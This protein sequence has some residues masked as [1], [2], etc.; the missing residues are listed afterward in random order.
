MRRRNILASTSI[1]SQLLFAF[2]L[3][4]L[5]PAIVISV[6]SA[7]TSY[8]IGRQ[9][10]LDQ[11]DSVVTLKSAEMDMWTNELGV[12]LDMLLSKRDMTESVLPLLQGRRSAADGRQ[13]HDDI[14][15]IL[16]GMETATHLFEYI[17]LMDA[18]GRVIVS[19]N[20]ALDGRDLGATVY[21]Q[22]GLQKN[23]I[24]P[25]FRED[26]RR[27]SS[28]DQRSVSS[29]LIIVAA[30]PIVAP[31]LGAVGVL[32]GFSDIAVLD[33]IMKEPMG[34]GDNCESYLIGSDYAPLTQLRFL[35]YPSLTEVKSSGVRLAVENKL[36]GHSAYLDYRGTPVIGSHAW[37]PV[38][39]VALIVELDQAEA[40]GPVTTMSIANLVV[41]LISVL[42]AILAASIITR[43][44]SVPLHAL[45]VTATQI[46]SGDLG[47]DA[48]V[49]RRDEIGNLA[50]AFNN[51]TGQLRNMIDELRAE[52]AERGRVEAEL[53]ASEERN[54]S[55]L[56]GAMDGFWRVDLRGQLLE[57]NQA[58]CHMSGY[59]ERELLAMDITDL[60]AV[61][62]QPETA[63]HI[64]KVMALGEDRFETRH[65]RKDGSAF[66][67][68]ISVQYKHDEGDSLLAFLRDITGRRQS[69]GQIRKSLAEKET[70]LKE[71][72]HRTKNNMGII[73]ALLN[74][75][76]AD[77]DDERVRTAF[78][79]VR[80]RIRSM[81]LVHQKLYEGNDLSHLNLKDYIRDLVGLLTESFLISPA[82]ISVT[83]DMEDVFVLIDTAI[84]CGLILNELITNA[85]KYAF[86]GGRPGEIKIHLR[87]SEGGEIRL[88]VSDSGVGL[89][90]GFD[91][92]RDG[93][94]GFQTITSLGEQQLNGK[95]RFDTSQGLAC[96]ILFR[97]DQYQSRV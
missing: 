67:V 38:L 41:A 45:S 58:Y 94:M 3:L 54:R 43:S 53:R 74:L 46:A 5:A 31:G 10:T 2:V 9:R 42:L 47:H 34:L 15:G 28:Q 71:L 57:V 90:L 50:R 70:L 85:L 62:R 69:E 19:T 30:H 37:L 52:L 6:T 78:A 75:Q 29:R 22:Q 61:E 83:T 48:D 76:E 65:L 13:A 64:E 51:M 14:L 59:S 97:D 36:R 35:A 12:G 27:D 80:D 79:D 7:V 73:I 4:V 86:P 88:G 23:F 24:T 44:I 87:R 33:R 96:E 66:E 55:V 95:V 91:I 60:E 17:C 25:P 26:T 16:D 49:E 18:K 68:E 84:P 32:A 92:K 89:P 8:V 77:I 82:G 21:Y 81:A 20:P 63:A 39:Q 93:H 1:F 72:H 11:L 56:R 40:F